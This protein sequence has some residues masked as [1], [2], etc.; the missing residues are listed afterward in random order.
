MAAAA[1]ASATPNTVLLLYFRSFVPFSFFIWSTDGDG[2]VRTRPTSEKR[3]RH[4]R[5]AGALAGINYK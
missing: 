4:A 1:A 2:M 5:V 3:D